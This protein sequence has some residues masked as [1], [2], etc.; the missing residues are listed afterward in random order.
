MK[1]TLPA[2]IATAL[3]FAGCP[4]TSNIKQLPNPENVSCSGLQY[5]ESGGMVFKDTKSWQSFWSTYCTVIDDKGNKM[6]APGIDFDKSMLVGVF[7]GQKPT[8][9][10]SI[11]IE[12]ILESPKSLIVEYSEESP[13]PGAMV[14]MALTY[15]CQLAL[16]SKSEK[17]VEF[18]RIDN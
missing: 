11:K 4:N 18:K 5:K 15:P 8:G 13:D 7:S 16:I 12:R 2:V 3:I 9:G 1:K 14:T 10:Y 17:T 6:P